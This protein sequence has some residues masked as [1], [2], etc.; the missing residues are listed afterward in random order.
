VQKLAGQQHVLLRPAESHIAD[1]HGDLPGPDRLACDDVPVSPC[2]GR[3]IWATP[4]GPRR[5][6][7]PPCY[8]VAATLPVAAGQ[9]LT[10]AVT[11]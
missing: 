2:G 4:G 1:S 6:T 9:F 8:P 5:D 11:Y 10:A 3:V 7:P